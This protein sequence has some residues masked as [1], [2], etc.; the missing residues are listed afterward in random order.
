MVKVWLTFGLAVGQAITQ[1]KG[2]LCHVENIPYKAW[3]L[4]AESPQLSEIPPQ[5]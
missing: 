1:K 5:S 3:D 2:D 4:G